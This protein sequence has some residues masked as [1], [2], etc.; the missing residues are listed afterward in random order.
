MRSLLLGMLGGAFG[1]GVVWL[2]A[3]RMID[4]QLQQ[5]ARGLEPQVREAVQAQVPQAVRQEL[6][7]TL[8]RYN[9]TPTTGQQINALLGLADTMGLIGVPARRAW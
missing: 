1:G 6:E 2:V 8:R 9:I 5:G 4:A 3:N 7:A